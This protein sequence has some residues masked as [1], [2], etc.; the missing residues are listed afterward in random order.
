MNALFFPQRP[1]K[2]PVIYA[3]SIEHPDYKGL[4]KIG[5]TDIDAQKRINQQVANI[6]LPEGKTFHRI[7]MVE[8]AVRPDGSVIEDHAI[9]SYLK[10]YRKNTVKHEGGEWFRCTVGDI[11]AAILA[12]KNRTENEENRT[13][14]FDMR[15][16][17]RAVVDKNSHYF[18][19]YS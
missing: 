1:E 16:E 15:P 6:K 2:H 4:L 13:Q 12:V 19:G 8:S 11:K 18:A 3:Y 5:Y 9:H 14:D 17:Q 7:E 10:R